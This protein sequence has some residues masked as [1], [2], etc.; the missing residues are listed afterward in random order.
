LVLTKLKPRVLSG[1][2][3][4]SKLN[5]TLRV[6]VKVEWKQRQEFILDN[7]RFLSV[8]RVINLR[9]PVHY[10]EDIPL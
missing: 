8:L 3:V 5:V 4:G 2:D 1:D 10:T 6:Y 7:R 9:V